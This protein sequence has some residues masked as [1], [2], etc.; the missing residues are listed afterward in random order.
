MECVTTRRIILTQ[1]G[2]ISSFFDLRGP[3]S[4]PNAE[5]GFVQSA[6]LGLCPHRAWPIPEDVV[7]TARSGPVPRAWQAGLLT[8]FQMAPRFSATLNDSRPAF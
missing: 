5:Q 3:Q 8:S 7:L 4:D 2:P 6:E 1:F